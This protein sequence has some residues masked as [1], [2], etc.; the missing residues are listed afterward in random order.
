MMISSLTVQS[1]QADSAAL[2]VPALPLPVD[3]GAA[4][5][6]AERIAH[7]DNVARLT[8]RRRGW[9]GVYHRRLAE[10]YSFLIVPGQR[11]LEIGC[12]RGDLLASVAPSQGVG[13]DFSPEMITRARQRQS[14]LKFI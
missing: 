11:V 7:W 8:D 1:A 4:G 6:R 9:S 5:Y 10:I 2:G 12:G 13:V 3:P 14:S